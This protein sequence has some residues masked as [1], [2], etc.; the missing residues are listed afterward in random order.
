MNRSITGLSLRLATLTAVICVAFASAAQA[1]AKGN[2]DDADTNK[3]GRVTLQEFTAYATQRLAAAN[4]R[5]S[6]KFKQLSPDEQAAR[7]QKRFEKL[8]HAHKGYLDRN[9]W[10]G[11]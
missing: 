2:F 8:D 10:K 7:I 6:S 11:S 4:G 1:Q 3:D 5:M 9:D